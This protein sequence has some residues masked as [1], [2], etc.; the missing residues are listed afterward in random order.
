MFLTPADEGFAHQTSLP[1]MMVASS[2]PNWRERYWFSV[3]DVRNKDF[4]LSGGFGKYPNKDV[5]EACAMV[6]HGDRQWN[7]RASRQLLPEAGSIAAGPFK[8]EIIEPFRHLRLRLDD[9]ESGIAYDLHWRADT[10]ALLEERHFEV[11]RA[12]VTHDI[13]RYVQL[14]RME[15][16]ITVGD[17]TFE[18]TL[19]S[20]WAQ[21][22]HSW[23]TRPMAPV[24]GDPPVASTEWN[25]LAFCPIQFPSFVLHIYLFETQA[26]EPT[27]LSAMAHFRDGRHRGDRVV[28]VDHDFV[29]D[30]AATVRTLV[31]GKISIRFKSGTSLDIDVT[32]LAPRAYLQGGGY[33]VDQGNWKGEN[34][35]EHEIWDLSEPTKLRDYIKGSS[36]HMLEARCGGETGYGIIE[37]LVRSGHIKYR[38]PKAAS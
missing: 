12:R 14:G 17:K 28:A 11:N 38:R 36:D 18:L 21:R 35:F 27:H 9:N 13:I 32:A 26:G 5:I 8:A 33:G 24:P 37:Y 22:D 3:Q 2:D 4:I 25:L 15:G 30:N 20:G 34:H 23:G 16:V 6:Q 7:V 10:P 1:L 19:D 29:W 31:G